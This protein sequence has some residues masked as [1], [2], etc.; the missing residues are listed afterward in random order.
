MVKARS[1]EGGDEV[2]T[3]Y[4][5]RWTQPS[6][7]TREVTGDAVWLDYDEAAH[8]ANKINRLWSGDVLNWAVEFEMVPNKTGLSRG[9]EIRDLRLLSGIAGERKARE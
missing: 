3:G 4:S 9:K 6:L 8:L 5:M 7:G 1:N 2:T